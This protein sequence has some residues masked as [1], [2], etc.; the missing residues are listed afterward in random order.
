MCVCVG[1]GVYKQATYT[2]LAMPGSNLDRAL[3]WISRTPAQP[4]STIHRTM[5]LTASS[6]TWQEGVR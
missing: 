4:T 6:C 1:G 2:A 5:L 3:P